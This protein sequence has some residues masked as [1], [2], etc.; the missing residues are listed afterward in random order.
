MGGQKA[1]P[2]KPNHDPEAHD[3][4][5]PVCVVALA[6]YRIGRYPV[7]VT[8]YRRFLESGGY[9]DTRYWASGGHGRRQAPAR[10]EEQLRFPNRPVVGVSWYA[11]LAY[12][13]W[14]G[15]SLPSEAEWE[16]AARGTDGRRL[17]WGNEPPD[18]SRCNYAMTV[19]HPTPVGVYPL[20]ATPEGIHDLAGNVREWTQS[21]WGTKP[22]KPDF[23]YPYA[24]SDGREDL[25]AAENV[26]RVLRGG[27]FNSNPRIV[28]CVSRRRYD[29]HSRLKYV[30]FRVVVCP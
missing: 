23:R 15:G 29:L 21:L 22:G 8:E 20:G 7:T 17:P 30:G 12:C 24:A 13:R 9:A 1:D 16:R 26:R 5:R 28:L 19:G 25:E 4:E 27:G 18:P 2:S 14:A 10:W 11:A 3:D 6:A